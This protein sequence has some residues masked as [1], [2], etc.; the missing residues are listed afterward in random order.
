MTGDDGPLG[1]VRGERGEG[2]VRCFRANL[3]RG[4]IAWI[5]G[6]GVLSQSRWG[7]FGVG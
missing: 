3:L 1:Y 7:R 6:W 4:D 2:R 5:G